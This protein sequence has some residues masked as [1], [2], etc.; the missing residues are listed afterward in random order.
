MEGDDKEVA[1]RDHFAGAGCVRSSLVS[2]PDDDVDFDSGDGFKETAFIDGGKCPLIRFKRSITQST[3][4]IL[5]K[6]IID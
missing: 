3:N 2:T 1:A 4:H 5:D 6:P